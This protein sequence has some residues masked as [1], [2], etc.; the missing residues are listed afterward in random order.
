MG[1]YLLYKFLNY[2]IISNVSFAEENSD[3]RY[4]KHT[5]WE[6]RY[7]PALN[8]RGELHT[9]LDLTLFALW[10]GSFVLVTIW[11]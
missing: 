8:P 3:Y 2:D 1:I 9:I 6:L 7:D 11:K 4:R 5:D 10:W